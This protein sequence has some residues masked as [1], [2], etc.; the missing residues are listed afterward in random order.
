MFCARKTISLHPFLTSNQR[1]EK[2]WAELVQNVVTHII[3]NI[4]RALFLRHEIIEWPQSS[5]QID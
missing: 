3:R 1:G 4:V 2:Y 5:L